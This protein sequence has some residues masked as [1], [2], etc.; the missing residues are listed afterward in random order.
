MTGGARL[1][2]QRIENHFDRFRAAGGKLKSYTRLRQRQSMRDHLSN[3]HLTSS[4]KFQ[5]FKQIIASAGVRSDDGNFISP[6]F[7]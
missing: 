5:R 4:D 6:K 7:K 1:S 2:N 3:P